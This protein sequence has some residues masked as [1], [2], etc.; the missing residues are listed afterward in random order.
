MRRLIMCSMLILAMFSFVE[1]MAQTRITPEVAATLPQFKVLN[2]NDE[3]VIFRYGRRPVSGKEVAA[4][5]PRYYFAT[6]R[7]RYIQPL[8]RSNLKNAFPGN[9][10]F[11]E[12]LDNHFKNDREL[13][14]YEHHHDMFKVNRLW[15][16]THTGGAIRRPAGISPSPPPAEG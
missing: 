11:H 6:S 9:T 8:T 1:T 5:K 13:V 3:I 16:E 15:A 4:Y 7:S 2:P 10:D 14:E 12:E